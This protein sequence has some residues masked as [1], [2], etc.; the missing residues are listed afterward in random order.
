MMK[1][2]E[3]YETKKMLQS[4]EEKQKEYCGK[5]WSAPCKLTFANQG[6]TLQESLLDVNDEV[7]RIQ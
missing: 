2:R 6:E 4:V 5:A 3:Y 7:K 1:T